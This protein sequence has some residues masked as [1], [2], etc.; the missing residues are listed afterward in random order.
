MK[1][2]ENLLPLIVAGLAYFYM[3]ISAWTSMQSGLLAFM[4]L[5]VAAVVQVIPVTANFLQIDGLNVSQAKKLS[6]ALESQ[7]N[8]WLGLLA[9]SVDA[10]IIIIILTP[11]ESVI[12]KAN[13]ADTYKA[14]ISSFCAFVFSFVFVKIFHIFPG[15]I[16][17]QRYRSSIL[18]EI[19]EQKA[20]EE[21]IKKLLPIPHN[22]EAD[23]NYGKIIQ[24][25]EF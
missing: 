25:P 8:F 13:D 14:C 2:P 15:I 4:G 9:S 5:L 17:L 6:L 7:Q 11:I 10:A 20:R 3:P 12:S 22:T 24:P 21:A 19:A 18:I 23:K 1:R 16:S